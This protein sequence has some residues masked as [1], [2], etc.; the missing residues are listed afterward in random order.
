MFLIK[1]TNNIDQIHNVL[2]PD[3]EFSFD[4]NLYYIPMQYSWLIKKITF[5]DFSV[6]NLLITNSNNILHQWRN[7][8]PFGIACY[9][10]ENREPQFQDDFLTDQSKLMLLSEE[11]KEAYT[12]S[13]TS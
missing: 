12:R 13:L 6:N 4:L 2:I 11:E 5:N 8:F 7:K 3:T 10:E 1:I 9:S